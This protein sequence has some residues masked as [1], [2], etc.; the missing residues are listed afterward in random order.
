MGRGSL[1]RRVVGIVRFYERNKP[2]QK[3]VDEGDVVYHAFS[4]GNPRQAIFLKHVGYHVF[5]RVFP[6]G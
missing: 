3:P 4:R 5:V 1:L 2:R 6:E